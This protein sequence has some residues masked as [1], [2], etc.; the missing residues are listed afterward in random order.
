M[1]GGP[2]PEPLHCAVLLEG[3]TVSEHVF[4]Q[5]V[6]K[7]GRL[8]TSHLTLEGDDVA[9]M[10]AVFERSNGRWRVVDLASSTGTVLNGEYVDRTAVLP[11]RGTLKFGAFEVRFKVGEG[12]LRDLVD[13]EA[14]AELEMESQDHHKALMES[15]MEEMERI[16]PRSH[17][18]ASFMRKGWHLFDDEKKRNYLRMMVETLRESRQKEAEFDRRTA[19]ALVALGP[20]GI[21]LIYDL[22]PNAALAKARQTLQEMSQAKASLELLRDMNL[23]KVVEK[24]STAVERTPELVTQDRPDRAQNLT[25]F[26][27]GHEDLVENLETAIAA[28][29]TILLACLSRA[30]GATLSDREREQLRAQWDSAVTGATSS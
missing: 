12:S 8:P 18:S 1:S 15:L 9:R 3:R 16:A 20:E 19:A 2:K 14:K 22:D 11:P 28:G 7:V 13:D 10:H 4:T 5:D 27:K 26:Q 21:E 25:Y 17:R 30:G 6:V 29:S 23:I 24:T